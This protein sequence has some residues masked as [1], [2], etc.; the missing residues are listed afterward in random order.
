MDVPRVCCTFSCW[1]AVRSTFGSVKTAKHAVA[2]LCPAPV[3]CAEWMIPVIRA[4][5]SVGS[6]SHAPARVGGPAAAAGEPVNLREGE[7][8]AHGTDDCGKVGSDGEEEEANI[9]GEAS[10][11]EGSGEAEEAEGEEEGCRR[12]GGPGRSGGRTSTQWRHR[13]VPP[14]LH[15]RAP[16]GAL[17]TLFQ[18]QHG[19]L[20]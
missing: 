19:K 13:P 5:N 14:P 12:L 9:V 1:R 17:P 2:L 3:P 8:G 11:D 10:K 7:R 15:L 6:A 18:L 20:L 4:W 16:S